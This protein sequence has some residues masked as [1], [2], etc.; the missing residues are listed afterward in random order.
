MVS[1][2]CRPWLQL[3]RDYGDGF[4]EKSLCRMVQFAATFP[5]ELIVATLLRQ[6]SWSQLVL[7]LPVKD[8]LQR[9]YYVQIC[10]AE[11]WSV[12][13]RRVHFRRAPKAAR[14]IDYRGR[15]PP[16]CRSR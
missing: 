2:L 7:L 16:P 9:K 10:C 6:L 11:R 4:A 1:R 15:T 12:R 5:E 14:V 13:R 8:P 3:T